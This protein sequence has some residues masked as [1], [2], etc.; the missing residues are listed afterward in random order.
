MTLVEKIVLLSETLSHHDVPHALGGALALAWCTLQARGTIDIDLNIFVLPAATR[1][2]LRFMPEGLQW[3]ED[4]I[5][6][7]ERDGQ[8]RLW[9]QETPVDIFL[10]STPYHDQLLDRISWEPFEGAQ[11][12]FLSCV[13]L[14]VFKAFF[15]R[16]KDRADLEAMREAGTLDVAAVAAILC[17]YLR[18]D[19]ERIASLYKISGQWTVDD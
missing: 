2:I 11:L 13:D 15:N 1:R 18:S 9:W 14:A 12:P 3:S 19:D 5:A 4:D 16:L 17:Q 10:N 7:L 8:S 6:V